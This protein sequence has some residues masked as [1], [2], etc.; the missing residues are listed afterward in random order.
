MENIGN[1]SHENLDFTRH[2]MSFDFWEIFLCF[3]L[4]ETKV[5]ATVQGHAQV[6][7]REKSVSLF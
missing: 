7:I 1:E 6:T 4:Q 3:R 2:N 5:G